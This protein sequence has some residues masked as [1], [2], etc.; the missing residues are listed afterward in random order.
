M[1]YAALAD[2]YGDQ[3]KHEMDT[4]STI[5]VEPEQSVYSAILFL[6]AISRAKDGFS[7]N[8]NAKLAIFLC[9]LNAT[10]QMG[11]VHV[12]D[13]YDHKNRLEA[14]RM[15][16]PASEVIEEGDTWVTRSDKQVTDYFRKRETD[17]KRAFIPKKELNELETV[18][19]ISPLCK[20]VGDGN[21]T[22]TCMPHSVKFA[23]DWTQLDT[24][25]DGVWTVEEARCDYNKVKRKRHISPETIFNNAIN[26]L[27]MQAAYLRH[28][29]NN[30]SLFLP[31]EVQQERAIPK[32]YF[33]FWAGDA[34]MCGLFDPNSCEAAAKSGVFG[35]ALVPG[36]LSPKSKGIY[37]LDSAIAYCYRMLS[38]GGGCEALLPSDFKR[39]REQRWERCGARTLVEGGRYSNPYDPTQSVRVLE[40]GYDSVEA[41]QRA[42]SRLYLFFLS[43]VITLWLLSLITELRELIKLGEFLWTFPPLSDDDPGTS[44]PLLQSP[45]SKPMSPPGT[46]GGEDSGFKFYGI[47]MQHRLVLAVVILVRFS[48]FNVLSQFGTKFLLGETNYFDLVMNSLALTFILTIDGM[49][50]ALV[51]KETADEVSDCKPFEFTTVLPTGKT[52]CGYFLKKECWGLFAVPIISVM[53]VLRH[54]YQIK[55]PMLTVLRCACTQEGAKCLDSIAYQAGWWEDYWGK[56]L[57]AA[58]HQIEALRIKSANNNFQVAH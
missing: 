16:L 24:D 43:L 23:L 22:F 34:M 11:V 36:R 15:L 54:N 55:E 46:Q 53:I 25:R 30:Y 39:N 48:V 50:F 56:V 29:G 6:P 44:S 26:G 28:S 47:A 5:V 31:E 42:T 35:A 32:A 9:I 4:G 37:D 40:A 58:I 8:R 19:D 57:P 13:V 27:R 7:W 10:L 18:N 41:Y 49:L 2:R 17:S 21:G 14:S 20:R 3:P 1:N 45:G 12:I 33:D 51:E 52:W 38:D